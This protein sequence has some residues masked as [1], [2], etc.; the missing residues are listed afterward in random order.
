MFNVVVEKVDGILVTTSNRVAEELGVLHKDLL[1]KI[2]NYISKFQSAELSADFYIPS[3]FKDSRNR[4][5]R[6]YLIT[7]KGIAQLI[8]GYSSAV[9]KAFDLNVA[10]INR[11]EEMEKLIYHQEFIEN[12]ELLTKIQKLENE[13]NQIPMTW[14]QVEVVKEQ[15]TET[16]LRRMRSTGISNRTFKLRLKKELVKDIQSRFGIDSLVELKYKDYLTVMPY[17]FN[18]I[19]PYQLRIENTQLQ[20]I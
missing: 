2:D 16:V 9:E 19:E 4:T 6:N 5:Y 18:W 15:I 3:K 17:I 7:K 20:M 1:E 12:R 13:L 10:Y 14:S 11:F 8:G